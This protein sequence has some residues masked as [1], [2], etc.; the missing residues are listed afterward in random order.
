MESCCSWLVAF[1]DHRDSAM[2]R[3]R[4]LEHHRH[5]LGEIRGI[6]NAM[7]TLAYMETRKLVRFLPA[8]RAVLE[9]IEEVAADFLSFHPGILPEGGH[10]IP[11]FLLIGAERGFCGDFNQTLLDQLAAVPD[12]DNTDGARLLAVG[13][14]LHPLLEGDGRVAAFTEGASVVEE[15]PV[16]LQQV[17]DELAILQTSEGSLSLYGLYHGDDGIVMDRLL[18]P[19]RQQLQHP[20]PHSHPPLLNLPP[21]AFLL[22][23]TDHYLFAALHQM[24]YT[25]LMM[26]NRRRVTHLEGAVQHLDEESADLGRQ[27][28]ALRQEEI[29]EEI[30]VI[31][32]SA[33]S[34]EEGP[35]PRGKA[36]T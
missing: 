36:K 1:P 25:S 15:V 16:V 14:K 28:N 12:G 21:E 35:L 2:S 17:V 3:R 13:R 19:F 7:K 34:L 23:L 5:S 18:P 26:E 27:Y 31:L 10:T 30:E 32:L 29:I 22:D 9:S 8:Q 6:M 11:V 24:L 33:A 4:D 20:L